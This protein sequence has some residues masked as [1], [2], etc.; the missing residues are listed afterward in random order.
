MSKHTGRKHPTTKSRHNRVIGRSVRRSVV[1]RLEFKRI[2]VVLFGSA[3][4]AL[5][6]ALL[7]GGRA[8]QAGAQPTGNLKGQA[9]QLQAQW[10]AQH[11][12][13][14]AQKAHLTL[15]TFASCAINLNQPPLVV[16]LAGKPGLPGQNYDSFIT[17]VSQ[18]KH[19]YSI[20]GEQNQIVVIER[21]VDMCNPNTA[22]AQPR[23]YVDPRQ[24]GQITLTGVH[25]DIVTFTTA[26]KT[27]GS[28][29]Y[30]TGQYLSA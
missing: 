26:A 1:G 7:T 24:P 12:K 25:G 9:A 2:R 13:V 8:A 23:F 28:F 5:S 6:L 10:Q 14:H 18:E 4:V 3:M 19:P 20:L 15:G 16:N 29:N 30:V 22:P 11:G 21:A 27:T 17:V